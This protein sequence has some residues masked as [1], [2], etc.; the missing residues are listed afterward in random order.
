MLCNFIGIIFMP[1]NVFFFFVFFLD[2]LNENVML[3]VYICFF[4]LHP[5]LTSSH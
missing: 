3:C 1:L 2:F 5:R 4:P